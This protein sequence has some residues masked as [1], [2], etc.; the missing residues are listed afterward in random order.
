LLVEM[1]GTP[2]AYRG[3]PHVLCVV[4]ELTERIL[5][6]QMLEMRVAA[7][8]RELA[9]LYDVTAVASA[10]LE[11]ETVLERSLSRVLEVMGCDV[12]GIHLLDE[13]RQALAV[14]A[15][16]GTAAGASG[17]SNALSRDGGPVGWVL[18]H[19]E[20]LVVPDIVGYPRARLSAVA[21]AEA[22]A[23]VGAPVHAKGQILGVLSVVGEPGRQFDAEEVAL[24]AS[25]ADQVGVA[26]DNARLYQQAERLAVLEE[27]DRLARELHDSVTQ[28]LYS[29]NLMVET[30]YRAAQAGDQQ[31]TMA[32]LRRVGEITQAAL[33]EMRLLLYELR[34]PALE[35]DRL[36]GALQKRLDAVE[37]RA[38]IE[39]RLL[40][41]GQVNVPWEVEEAL[42]R[43]AVEALNNALRHAAAQSVSV[44]ICADEAGIRLEVVDDGCGFSPEAAREAG[45]MGLAS[46]RQRAERVGGILSIDSVPG[47]ETRVQVSVNLDPK[48]V[49][50]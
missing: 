41:E 35:Q 24:L 4:R 3:G 50:L 49:P 47:I 26:V 25:I 15:W 7:R 29:A 8:T 42:Y 9:A 33:K 6:R 12:G 32:Y 39:T 30:G 27:R 23:Y 46:M 2:L 34:P 5:T 40:I 38:G 43:I 36:A 21:G 28:T 22:R 1:N 45:G 17:E 10:S 16:H 20:P 13:A 11:L 18:E 37:G 14:A 31:N 44:T 19:G 48:E